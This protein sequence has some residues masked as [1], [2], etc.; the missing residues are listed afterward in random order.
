MKLPPREK[1]ASILLLLACILVG[2]G[3]FVLLCEYGLHWLGVALRGLGLITL[4]FIIAWLLAR[5]TRPLVG[6]LKNKL[7]LPACIW[8]SSPRRLQAKASFL[9]TTN[10]LSDRRS[11]SGCAVAQTPSTRLTDCSA[12]PNDSWTYL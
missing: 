1:T 8:L 11:T 12:E 5:L 10:W 9:P 4:P 6:F 2:L 3:I 7:H